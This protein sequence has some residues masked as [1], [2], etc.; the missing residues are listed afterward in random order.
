MTTPT[1]RLS[2]LTLLLAI[3]AT[4]A[5]CNQP[6]AA[7]AAQAAAA[8]ALPAIDQA[9]LCEVKG[10][11]HD[12]VAQSC[13]PGQKVIYLPDSWGNEQLPVIFAAVNCD[14]R[15]S[16]TITKGAVACIYSPMT[17]AKTS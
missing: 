1:L 7:Q 4:L 8:P 17:P 2:A 9:N 14:M 6:Q 11:Q 10:W 15:Y 3:S 16:V 13:K 12:V 5:G